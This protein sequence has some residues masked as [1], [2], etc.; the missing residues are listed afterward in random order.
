MM[1]RLIAVAALSMLSFGCA[2][3][4]TA[5]TLNEFD[6]EAD[7]L[8]SE[9]LEREIDV[10][11]DETP[12]AEAFDAIRR[13]SGVNLVVR[14]PALEAGAAPRDLPI[15]LKLQ[16]VP[17]RVALKLVLEQVAAAEPL[18]PIGM[19]QR[20]GVVFV[21]LESDLDRERIVDVYDVRELISNKRAVYV[22]DD[23]HEF[24]LNAALG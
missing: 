16:R 12:L 10:S 17:A 13:K 7:R 8:T 15:T 18:E 6:S 20:D 9:R 3:Q 11:F 2:N 23:R 4:P 1:F 24:D 14:W 21:S 22:V 5:S 19:R